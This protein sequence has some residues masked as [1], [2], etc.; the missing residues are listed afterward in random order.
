[1][2]Q[3]MIIAGLL[4]IALPASASE[5]LRAF[6]STQGG[7]YVHYE[8][9]TAGEDAFARLT[10]AGN[11]PVYVVPVAPAPND[12]AGRQLAQSYAEALRA[13][14]PGAVLGDA[15]ALPAEGYVVEVDVAQLEDRLEVSEQVIATGG[16]A[17]VCSSV[18]NTVECKVAGTGPVP[19]G[20]RTAEQA[21]Q[22]VEARMRLSRL[23]NGALSPVYDDT[24]VIRYTE[25]NCRNGMAAAITLAEALAVDALSVEPVNIRFQSRGGPLR[26]DRR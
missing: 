7:V 3:I 20:T 18:G 5:A 26:C 12:A 4:A 24:Y 17:T 21:G 1:M 15:A 9:A 16:A 10:A 25:A 11:T 2:K 13:V 14:L 19:M 6:Q 8:R 22:R 23:E